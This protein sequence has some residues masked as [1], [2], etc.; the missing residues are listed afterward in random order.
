MCHPATGHL[1]SLSP[2]YR[3][4][5]ITCHP[6]TGH[7]VTTLSPYITCHPVTDIKVK[8]QTVE[9]MMRW[10]NVMGCM[11]PTR[12]DMSPRL[13][14]SWYSQ[15][16]FRRCMVTYLNLPHYRGRKIYEPPR[17]M[18]VSQAALQLLEIISNRRKRG[19][20]L[21]KWGDSLG[22]EGRSWQEMGDPSSG[23]KVPVE[24]WRSWCGRRVLG[25][26]IPRVE[27]RS[28]RGEGESRQGRVN[29]LH[30][31]SDQ[32][33]VCTH[34]R[35]H[36]VND[37]QIWVHWICFLIAGLT[38]KTLCVGVARVGST[39]QKMISGT[40][41]T[42]AES[43]LGEPL[44]S[45][46]IAGNVHHLEVEMLKL[47]TDDPGAIEKYAEIV[48]EI[49]VSI[50]ADFIIIMI[51]KVPTKDDMSG[52]LEVKYSIAPG[53]CC[54]CS[55]ILVVVRCRSKDS[56]AIFIFTSEN[57]IPHRLTRHLH[58]YSKYCCMQTALFNRITLMKNLQTITVTINNGLYHNRGFS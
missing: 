25:K 31:S 30:Y 51:R 36:S 27:E 55:F 38:E 37:S 17:Y 3:S 14:S 13:Y 44:H 28:N 58:T 6:V 46:V 20:E 33:L 53:H 48:W 15:I 16:I 56:R 22:G 49:T 32:L 18:T 29:L 52:D 41:E 23:E 4:P 35:S 1:I 9:N 57:V 54:V 47:F 5:Y 42:L 10:V 11:S 26:G 8:E 7:L 50:Q 12:R 21:S 19:E 43:E 45:L 34:H 24:E 40:L 2:C 39:N